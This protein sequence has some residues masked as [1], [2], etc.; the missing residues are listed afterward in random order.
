MKNRPAIA[1]L[2]TR[3][4]SSINVAQINIVTADP[5]RERTADQRRPIHSNPQMDRKSA[6]NSNADEMVN[7]QYIEYFKFAM[8]RMCPSNKTDVKLQLHTMRR[9]FFRTLGVLNKSKNVTLFSFPFS[10]SIIADFLK[11]S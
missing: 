6:G 4:T 1:M 8:L 9:T 3:M 11:E 2:V 10:Y 5:A 7:V